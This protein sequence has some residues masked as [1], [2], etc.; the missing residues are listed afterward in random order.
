[1]FEL[2]HFGNLFGVTLC[3]WFKLCAKLIIVS[4]GALSEDETTKT[5]AKKCLVYS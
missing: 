3:I 1:M 4:T 2:N 5:H